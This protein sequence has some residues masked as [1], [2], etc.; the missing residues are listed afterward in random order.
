MSWET[1]K[2]LRMSGSPSYM[3][4]DDDVDCPFR[5]VDKVGVR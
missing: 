2:V 3:R 1:L 5:E 4:I